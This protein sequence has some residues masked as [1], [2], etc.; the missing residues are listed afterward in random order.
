MVV[1]YKV[2]INYELVWLLYMEVELK[3]SSSLINIT[4]VVLLNSWEKV[5]IDP[6]I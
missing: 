5:T 3:T 4:K 6:H 2:V 1:N